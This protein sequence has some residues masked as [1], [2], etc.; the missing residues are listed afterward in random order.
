MKKTVSLLLVL[1]LLTSLFLSNGLVTLAADGTEPEEQEPLGEPLPQDVGFNL[2]NVFVSRIPDSNSYTITA[3]H[4]SIFDRHTGMQMK[5]GIDW[6]VVRRKKICP[7]VAFQY[8]TLPEARGWKQSS[9]LMNGFSFID[10]KI[11]RV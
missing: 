10:H 9:E 8:A 5:Y 11:I 2:R 4:V 1:M 6:K 3:L 7:R